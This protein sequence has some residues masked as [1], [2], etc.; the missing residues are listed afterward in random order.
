MTDDIIFVGLDTDKTGIDIAV[1][2][3]SIGSEVRYFGRIANTP[4]ALTR[5]VKAIQGAGQGGGSSSGG[6]L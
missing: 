2:E 3:G 1:A 5:A 4:E 6:L